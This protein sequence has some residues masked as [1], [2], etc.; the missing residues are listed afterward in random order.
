MLLHCLTTQRSLA[1][2][3]GL[4][5]WHALLASTRPR[6]GVAPCT[7]LCTTHTAVKQQLHPQ[8]SAKQ[9]PIRHRHWS[10]MSTSLA[11]T[12]PHQMQAQWAACPSQATAAGTDYTHTGYHSGT[13]QQRRQ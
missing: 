12:Y 2:G 3:F 4:L 5:L 11:L 10:V 6:A 13:L 1:C 9:Q 8:L 7:A